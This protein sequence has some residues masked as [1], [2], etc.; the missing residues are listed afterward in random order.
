MSLSYLIYSEHWLSLIAS[1]IWSDRPQLPV[2][3]SVYFYPSLLFNIACLGGITNVC[4][5]VYFHH[6]FNI[7]NAQKID[8]IWLY[9][10]CIKSKVN[11]YT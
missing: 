2:V 3:Y 10:K 7:M 5:W 1:F 11:F 4:V 6:Q 8:Q 9:S